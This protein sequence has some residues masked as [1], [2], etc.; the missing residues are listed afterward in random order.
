MFAALGWVCDPLHG[1]MPTKT[2]YQFM[3]SHATPFALELLRAPR[4]EP[5]IMEKRLPA[6]NPK[7]SVAARR[8]RSN[9]RPRVGFQRVK[10]RSRS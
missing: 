3:Y 1:C 10:T 5:P 7:L 2:R 6:P 4:A 8:Q 9:A